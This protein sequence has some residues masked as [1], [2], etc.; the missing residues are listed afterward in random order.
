MSTAPVD[1]T[2]TLNIEAAWFDHAPV[3][4]DRSA[5]APA[6]QQGFDVV[7][8]ET[9]THL[10]G[11]PGG[12]TI[13]MTRDRN[14]LKFDIR[15]ATYLESVNTVSVHRT[16]AFRYLYLDFIHLK[17]DAPR[18]MGAAMLWRMVRA[19]DTLGLAQIQCHAAG[20]INMP[21]LAN[22]DRVMGYY[23]WP[24]YGFDGP[25]I[26]TQADQDIADLFPYFPEGLT[27]G[28]V[29]TLSELFET[30]G[31]PQYWMV[32]GDA[33]DLAF[34]VAASSP[35]VITLHRYLNEKEFFA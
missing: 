11:A 20:G 9:I 31:G 17:Q 22:G 24:R 6:D 23:A 21:A 3:T 34:E 30:S 18:G 32:A 28:S 15:H 7:D 1:L 10:C 33:R 5:V 8:D 4:V 27:D 14:A 35:S 19:C 12:A 26:V 25:F 13:R 16:P 2:E 29:S